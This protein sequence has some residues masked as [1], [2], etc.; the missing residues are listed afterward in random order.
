MWLQTGSSTTS[1]LI[2]GQGVCWLRLILLLTC[3]LLLKEYG[4]LALLVL[5]NFPSFLF[6][7]LTEESSCL[8]LRLRLRWQGDWR[9]RRLH[10]VLLL[11]LLLLHIGWKRVVY[12][13]RRWK[14]HFTWTLGNELLED[15]ITNIL[16][17]SLNSKII[18][19]FLLCCLTIKHLSVFL[20]KSLLL[21]VFFNLMQSEQ[22]HPTCSLKYA[23]RLLSIITLILPLWSALW[24]IRNQ[25]NVWRLILLILRSYYSWGRSCPSR[26]PCTGT[27]LFSKKFLVILLSLPF[28]SFSST[29]N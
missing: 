6:A 2:A 18:F 1:P 23:T 5:L 20:L 14:G 15:L 25:R 27:I 11:L 24:R 21:F 9:I 7:L 17:A 16:S 3:H 4:I 26:C 22:V 29:L 8:L 28:I 13:I 19:L 12:V 10:Q